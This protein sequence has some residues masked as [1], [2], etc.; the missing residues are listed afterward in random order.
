MEG[1]C[2]HY[3]QGRHLGHCQA[4][5]GI[6]NKWKKLCFLTTYEINADLRSLQ[7]PQKKHFAQGL[8]AIIHR[9]IGSCGEAALLRPERDGKWC[10]RVQLE[11]IAVIQQ[12]FGSWKTKQS[13]SSNSSLRLANIKIFL[14]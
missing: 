11:E 8:V 7:L 10:L 2:G 5:T 12:E 3:E 9:G 14:L 1:A 6:I 4:P 13:T